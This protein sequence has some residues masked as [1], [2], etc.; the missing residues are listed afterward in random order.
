[1][2]SCQPLR[3]LGFNCQ[4]ARAQAFAVPRHE[5]PGLCRRTALKKREGAGNAGRWPRPWP[6][7]EKKCRRQVPQVRPKTPGIPRAM[8]LTLIRGLLGAPGFLATVSRQRA[9]ARCARHQRR[10][11]RTARF[12]VRRPAFVCREPN[13]HRIP[14]PRVVT[15]ARN[16]PLLEAG[17]RHTITIS[18]KKK[19]IFSPQGSTAP[20]ALKQFAKTVPV[21]IRILR[22]TRLDCAE[23]PIAW[24]A[25][26]H[27]ISRAFLPWRFAY[28]GPRRTTRLYHGR[29]PETFTTT[30]LS[31][32]SGNVH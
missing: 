24:D 7:C 21:R 32:E 22:M 23:I 11:A 17:W 14:A 3:N 18:E 27:H 30:N 9:C 5:L 15:I 16:A 4:T 26:P 19:E 1:M 8:V 20:I 28:L 10:D 12:H 25:R 13:V 31:S 2:A 6:A 29:H